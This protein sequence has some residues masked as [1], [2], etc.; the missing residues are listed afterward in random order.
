MRKFDRQRVIAD[1][2]AAWPETMRLAVVLTGRED[3]ARGVAR[4]VI[5][6]A[7]PVWTTWDDDDD[8]VQKGWFFHHTLLNTRRAHRHRPDPRDEVLLRSSPADDIEYAAFVRA[9]R[10]LPF[11]QAEAWLLSDALG[12]DLRRSAT[13]MDLS[14]TATANHL[15]A[16]RRAL[17][18][19]AG[20]RYAALLGR[21]REAAH[22]YTPD[23]LAP[24]PEVRAAVDR[25]LW[26]RRI[27]RVLKIVLLAAVAYAV[28]HV[29]PRLLGR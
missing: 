9:L 4:F 6:R 25:Y 26:P 12:L 19:I 11:Q 18:Q 13:T 27:R 7:V 29:L 3:V 21:V 5:A 17:S 1:L 8:T 22:A 16:A 2:S 28:W 23:G 20:D 24:L 10:D 14:T 15:D